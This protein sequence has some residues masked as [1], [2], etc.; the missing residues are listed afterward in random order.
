M[1]INTLFS[2]PLF[3]IRVVIILILSICLHELG[4]GIAALSQGDDT[5]RIKGHMTMNPLV[6][7]GVHSL[8][9]LAFAGIAWGQM[10]VNPNRFR[11][12]KWGSILV[13]AAGPL[14]NILLGLLGVLII[15]V[16]LY[17][18]WDQ[19]ISLNFFYLV[20]RFNFALCL[21]NLIP[22]PPLDGFR[23]ASELFPSIRELGRSQIG[24]ALF[25]ILFISGAGSQLFVLADMIVKSLIL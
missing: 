24:L 8:F 4:H 16:T 10:P 14:T 18:S 15:N 3:Y 1:F 25:M 20:A 9:F 5:P 7:M 2:N 22:I 13:A 6:H 21:F 12:P 19:V 23:I 17:F 11:D